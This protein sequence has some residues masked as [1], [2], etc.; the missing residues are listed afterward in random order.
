[1]HQLTALARRIRRTT[2]V[3]PL[4]DAL[5]LRRVLRAIDA[6]PW[7]VRVLGP[8]EFAPYLRC[9]TPLGSVGADVASRDFEWIIVPQGGL[10]TLPA[11]L[12]IGLRDH[13]RCTVENRR[14]LL[15][16]ANANS[17]T[18]DG[19]ALRARI[20]ALLPAHDAS[21]AP[22]QVRTWKD[23][24]V[25]VTTFERP[26]ALERSLPQIA[27]LGA[28]VLVVDDGSREAAARRNQATALA[29]GVAYLRLPVNRG[30]SAAL[31]VGLE[32]LLAD[33]AITWVSCLQDDVDVRADLL[34]VLARVEDREQRPILSGYDATAHPALERTEVAGIPIVLKRETAG[35]HLHAHRDYWRG[36]LP[37]PTE[38]IGAPKRRWEAP[39]E[40]SWITT[41]APASAARRGVPIACLP[42]LVRTFL[43]HPGDSTWDNPNS[44]E[45]PLGAADPPTPVA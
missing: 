41:G 14:Y 40:D 38:Y 13:F 32:Y 11:P 34:S 31:N 16:A 3:G 6:D 37:I 22:L 26:A 25:L 20:D 35:V 29:C 36:V 23:R 42:G 2:L 9:L 27:C 45:P 8:D 33:A 17:S 21:R 5:Q 10:G 12:L 24:A 30:L 15:F 7:R 44:P 4:I 1:M 39:L 18:R 19:A 28:A 43:W